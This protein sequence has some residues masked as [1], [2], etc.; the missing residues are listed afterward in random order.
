MAVDGHQDLTRG[1]VA[2]HLRRQGT[3]FALGL[4]AIFSFEAVDLF[5][6]SRLGDAPLAAISFCFPVIWLIYGIGIG[7]EAAAASCV[8]RAKVRG[9]VA[10]VETGPYKVMVR[11]YAGWRRAK[12]SAATPKASQGNE[13]ALFFIT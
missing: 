6:I 7:F 12:T 9:S 2:A 5:F 11:T 3:P 4:V 1:P 13:P 10:S 8:S